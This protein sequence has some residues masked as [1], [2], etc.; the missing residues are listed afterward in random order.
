ML[1]SV[2]GVINSSFPLPFSVPG[3]LTLGA[4]GQ[5]EFAGVKIHVRP[6]Q[7]Q[8]FALTQPDRQRHGVQRFEP[9]ALDHLEEQRGFR[10]VEH[11]QG[12]LL[13][14]R[15][16]R[17]WRP[18]R[19]LDSRTCCNCSSTKAANDTLAVITNTPTPPRYCKT[20]AL[21]SSSSQEPKSPVG[22]PSCAHLASATPF[23]GPTWRPMAGPAHAPTAGTPEQS[24]QSINYQT[25]WSGR[26]RITTCSPPGQATTHQRFPARVHP[27]TLPTLPDQ[28]LR[29]CPFSKSSG[30]PQV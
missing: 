10:L 12:P 2:F 5:R 8:N 27:T 15:R 14:L 23:S 1:F 25:R 7:A 17:K 20:Q 24:A 4:S 3:L 26:F 28:A 21:M 18:L 16:L 29:V 6:A 11:V 30:I 22:T 13:Q 19:A 9:P